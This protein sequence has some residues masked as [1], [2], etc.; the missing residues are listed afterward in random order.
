MVICDTIL[1]TGLRRCKNVIAS[2]TKSELFD[3]SN[4]QVNMLN[5]KLFGD[6]YVNLVRFCFY[7]NNKPLGKIKFYMRR[8]PLCTIP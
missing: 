3:Y 6:I 7:C 5:K 1:F 8:V 4:F 2:Y